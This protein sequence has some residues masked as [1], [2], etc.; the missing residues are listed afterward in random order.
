MGIRRKFIKKIKKLLYGDH[1]VLTKNSGVNLLL[2]ASNYVDRELLG[3]GSY[4]ESQVKEVIQLIKTNNIKY[5]IDVGSNIG[6]YS[7][8]VAAE[9]DCL[10]K[11]IA[12]EAQIE[13]YNQ[14]CGN[15]RINDF[16][17]LIDARNIGASDK[18]GQ[19]EFLVNKGSSTGTSRIKE[20]MPEGTN[21]RKFNSQM[22]PVDTLDNILSG[23]AGDKFF[24]KIDVEGHEKNVLLGMTD[25]LAKNQCFFQIE[26]LDGQHQRMESDFGLRK[27]NQI[28]SDAY[29]ESSPLIT[30]EQTPG[31]G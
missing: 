26:F 27:T 10:E 30:S 7:L 21:L 4:E 6:L 18:T 1:Y 15:I 31:S 29:F 23:I 12:I 3:R 24:F 11:I 5:F 20:T 17:R 16:D 9:C 28:G 2:R 22:V 25:I 19:I 13:N 8:R 14:L